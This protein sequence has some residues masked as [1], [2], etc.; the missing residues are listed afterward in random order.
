MCR[1]GMSQ[2]DL[3]PHIP[4]PLKVEF[5]VVEWRR[6]EKLRQRRAGPGQFLILF[7]GDNDGGGNHP[8]GKLVT[9]VT[10]CAIRKGKVT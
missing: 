10:C 9:F 8:Q 1:E 2:V 7:K 6:L 3:P 5:D 4:A